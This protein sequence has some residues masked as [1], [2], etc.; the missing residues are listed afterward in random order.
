MNTAV[1]VENVMPALDCHRYNKNFEEE[2]LCPKK[3]LLYMN[4]SGEK[5]FLFFKSSQKTKTYGIDIESALDVEPHSEERAC[6]LLSEPSSPKRLT[7]R[8]AR[9]LYKDSGDPGRGKK[10]ID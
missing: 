6:S 10:I 2:I 9:A 8:G 1:V 4:E 5:L 3:G 7:S